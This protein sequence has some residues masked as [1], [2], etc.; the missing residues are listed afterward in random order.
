TSIYAARARDGARIR[1]GVQVLYKQHGAT[2]PPP[3]TG[4]EHFGFL[5]GVSQPGLRGRLSDDPRDVLT[6]RQ[7]PLDRNQGKPGQDLL[8]PG[9][10]VFGYP[11]QDAGKP[12]E[13]PGDEVHAGPEWADH[14]SF[15][16]VRRLRQDVPAFHA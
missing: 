15:L 13:E 6:L 12:V 11:G 1:S 9:E 5:D 7:N 8:W 14:G 10:F 2:L 16:V 3:L 4:H